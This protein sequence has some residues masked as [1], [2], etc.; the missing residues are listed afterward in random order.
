MT[1]VFTPYQTAQTRALGYESCSDGRCKMDVEYEAEYRH[2]RGPGYKGRVF[3]I[4]PRDLVASLGRGM[5]SARLLLRSSGRAR[6]A[7]WPVE[8]SE[9]GI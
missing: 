5:S 8:Q 4:P 9:T 7:C 6:R 2:E 1:R 3:D